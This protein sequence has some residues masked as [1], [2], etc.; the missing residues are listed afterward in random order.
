MLLPRL[1]LPRSR[2]NA[3]GRE[4]ESSADTGEH[5]GWKGTGLIPS[6]QLHLG[7]GVSPDAWLKC[8]TSDG[9]EQ[10][11]PSETSALVYAASAPAMSVGTAC[12]YHA[13]TLGFMALRNTLVPHSFLLNLNLSCP[14]APSSLQ[15]PFFRR[16][17]NLRETAIKST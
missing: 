10:M 16:K 14:S 11:G 12:S 1:Q 15:T 6:Q 4:L 7:L 8:C 9:P 2:R 5:P 17:Q 13:K 3:K